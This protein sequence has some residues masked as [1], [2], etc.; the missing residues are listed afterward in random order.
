MYHWNP[1]TSNSQADID[2]IIR[3]ITWKPYE[4]ERKKKTKQKKK[5]KKKKYKTVNFCCQIPHS[6]SL[7]NELAKRFS[8]YCFKYKDATQSTIAYHKKEDM[9][10]VAKKMKQ[11]RLAKSL[12]IQAAMHRLWHYRTFCNHCEDKGHKQARI[13]CLYHAKLL[14]EKI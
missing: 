1:K 5:K 10:K 13:S 14:L 11:Y 7:D 9:A 12:Y 4:P 6:K 3:G 2:D 8:L